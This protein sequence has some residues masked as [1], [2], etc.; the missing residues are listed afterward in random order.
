[1]KSEK[2]LDLIF[3]PYKEVVIERV[4]SELLEKIGALPLLILLQISKNKT[5][6]DIADG[7]CMQIWVI[8]DAAEELM[9]NGLLVQDKN[10]AYRL[11]EIGRS[12][13]RI[14]DFIKSFQAEQQRRYAVNLFTCQLEQ[15]RNEHCFA[16]TKCPDSHMLQLP[17]KLQN[18]ERLIS[19]PN[20]EN[21]LEYMKQYLNLAEVSLTDDDY[22]FIQFQLH[23]EGEVFY[24]PYFVPMDAYLKSEA[25]SEKQSEND[26]AIPHDIWL[27][28]PLIE[29]KMVYEYTAVSSEISEALLKLHSVAPEFLTTSGKN[30]IEKIRQAEQFTLKRPTF[31]IDA[32]RGKEYQLDDSSTITS[33]PPNYIHPF[34]LSERYSFPTEREQAKITGG[35]FYYRYEVLQKRTVFVKIDFSRLIQSEEDVL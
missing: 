25:D 10:Q 32:Y 33:N 18:A 22:E 4:S 7:I 26:I 5:V 27:S 11:T 17:N 31:V 8:R 23:T 12:Y 1:M 20:Y 16:N 2:K 34:M 30:H 3:C 9:Q 24:V 35:E 14:Y 6:E 28:V 29:G 19:T 21:T 15:V 13:V